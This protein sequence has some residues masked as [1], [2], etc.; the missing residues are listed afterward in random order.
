MEDHLGR[1]KNEKKQIT[2]QGKQDTK[3]EKVEHN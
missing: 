1:E 3:Q 2:W